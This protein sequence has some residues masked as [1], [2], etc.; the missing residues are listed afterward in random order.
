ME[1]CKSCN[2][3]MENNQHGPDQNDFYTDWGGEVRQKAKCSYCWMCMGW[4][5]REA[6]TA[7]LRARGEATRKP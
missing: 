4:E 1:Y 7:G 2:H 6:M 3:S 5:S